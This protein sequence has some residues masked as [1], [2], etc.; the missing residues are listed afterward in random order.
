MSALD[1]LLLEIFFSFS[2]RCTHFICTYAGRTQDFEQAKRVGALTVGLLV[3][4]ADGSG[5]FPHF[6]MPAV[7]LHITAAAFLPQNSPSGFCLRARVTDGWMRR[8]FWSEKML[9]LCAPTNCL[10][11]TESCVRPCRRRPWPWPLSPRTAPRAKR[12][13]D[14]APAISVPQV[15]SR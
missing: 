5:A 3:R 12:T 14:G 15:A 11:K 9:N 4:F 8:N 1:L 7:C 2:C 13:S 10:L 6:E